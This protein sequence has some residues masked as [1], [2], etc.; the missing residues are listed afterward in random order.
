MVLWIGLFCLSAEGQS[1]KHDKRNRALG[2]GLTWIGPPELHESGRSKL[3]RP[4]EG[5][6]VE[7]L[8]FAYVA[9]SS[10]LTSCCKHQECLDFVSVPAM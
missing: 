10:V 6:A 2:P 5:C 3:S 9:S 8:R 1:K 7:Y 4:W